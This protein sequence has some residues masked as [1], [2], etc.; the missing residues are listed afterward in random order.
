MAVTKAAD[1]DRERVAEYLLPARLERL[2]GQNS[3]P[4]LG[5]AETK[6]AHVLAV[7]SPR[8]T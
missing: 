4:D 1:T 5:V 7:R 6:T 3:A 8:N 2:R